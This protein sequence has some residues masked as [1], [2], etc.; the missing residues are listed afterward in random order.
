[1]LPTTWE[2]SDELR[3]GG[4]PDRTPAAQDHGERIL[5]AFTEAGERDVFVGREFVTHILLAEHPVVELAAVDVEEKFATT[6]GRWRAASCIRPMMAFALSDHFK[7]WSKIQLSPSP[8]R[9]KYFSA[10][11][12]LIGLAAS[13]NAKRMGG[14]RRHQPW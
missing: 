3:R 5:E 8:R 12:P 9:S 14:R 7:Q 11:V 13:R 2:T 6:P 10:N 4:A 1:M